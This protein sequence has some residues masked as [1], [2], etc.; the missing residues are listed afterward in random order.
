MSLVGEVFKANLKLDIFANRLFNF[1]DDLHYTHSIFFFF[2]MLPTLRLLKQINLGTTDKDAEGKISC[3][4]SLPDICPQV[5]VEEKMMSPFPLS[6][7]RSTRDNICVASS[8]GHSDSGF[9]KGVLSFFFFNLNLF[10]YLFI[11][12]CVGSSFLCEGF[13]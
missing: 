4:V 8:L 5:L 1:L 9:G 6:K 12:G 10:I 2:L 3:H 11:F 7:F 13:L